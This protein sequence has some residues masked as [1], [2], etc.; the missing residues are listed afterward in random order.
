MKKFFAVLSLLIL[1]A[2][3]SLANSLWKSSHTATADTNQSLC[4]V[5]Q[6]S[7]SCIFKGVKVG[8][9]N[10]G[11]ITIYNSQGAASGIFQQIFT[12]AAVVNNGYEYGD[13]VVM[14]SGCTYSTSA[15]NQS[16]NLLYDC[17]K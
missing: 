12:T 1:G 2:G 10:S 4:G 13:G 8:H 5:N 16:V 11:T 17:R 7:N 6:R 3:I 14:S 9:G 15:A